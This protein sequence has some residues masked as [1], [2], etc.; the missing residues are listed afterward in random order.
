MSTQSRILSIA[1]LSALGTAGYVSAVPLTPGTLVGSLN[2]VNAFPPTQFFVGELAQDGQP[3]LGNFGLAFTGGNNIGGFGYRTINSVTIDQR[4]N[5]TRHRFHDLRVYTSPTNFVPIALADTQ[6][7]QTINIPG[8]LTGD[9][10]Y[11][12]VESHYTTGSTDSNPG[13]DAISFDGTVGPERTDFNLGRPATTTN[14]LDDVSFPPSATTNG[15][16]SASGAAGG[17]ASFFTYN[18]GTNRSLSV[19]YAS[20]QTV[21]VV[22]VA[23]ET[24]SNLNGLQRPVPKFITVT[25][26]NANSEVIILE[27]HVL[28]YGQYNLT[29]PFANTTSLTLTLPLDTADYY[30][31]AED[32]NVGIVEFQAFAPVP[33]PASLSLLSLG[34]LGLLARRRRA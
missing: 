19:S 21:G 10:F 28:Q 33:E 6:A 9:Y 14:A 24:F 27:P 8:G 16:L 30:T 17:E 4:D 11:I 34:T 5:P 31:T 20:P 1:F 15:Y 12:T 22:G 26:S 7:S 2:N 25:D 23:F 3:N 32:S 29:T 18:T 13:V